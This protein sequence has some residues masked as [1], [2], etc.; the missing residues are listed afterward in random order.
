MAGGTIRADRAD[1]ATGWLSGDALRFV[2][3]C[4]GMFARWQKRLLEAVAIVGTFP[5]SLALGVQTSPRNLSGQACA[6]RCRRLEKRMYV[7]QSDVKIR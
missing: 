5:R 6:G 2:R 3:R 4:A 7:T 1:L